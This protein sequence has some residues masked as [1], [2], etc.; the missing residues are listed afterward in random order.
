MTV[1]R[2]KIIDAARKRSRGELVASQL[3]ILGDGLDAAATDAEIPD[4]R[5]ALMFACAHPAI[6]TGIR[7]PLILQ[8]V[9]GLDAETIASAF[10]TS[11]AAMAKRLVRAKDK[12]RQAGIAF[13]IPEREAL[14]RRLDAVLDAIYAAFAEG[15]T[16]PWG[17][18]AARRDLTEEALFLARLVGRAAAGRAGGARPAGAD[19]ARRGAASGPPHAATATTCRLPNRTRRC[20]IGRRS[21]RPRRCCGAPAAHGVIGRYQLEAALQSA[22][23]YRCRTGHANWAEIVQLYDALMAHCPLARRRHQSR[24]RARRSGRRQCRA[25]SPAGGRGRCQARRIPTLLGGARRAAGENAAPKAKR[26]APTTWQSASSATRPFAV[27]A[28]AAGG[29]GGLIACADRV[30]WLNT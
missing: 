16:D 28:A 7:A 12:I 13:A 3:Q 4:R 1:A 21:P 25:G 22:H 24:A 6:E 23:V 17:T 15:W 9:L 29:A 10:L 19:A 27:S 26:A 20:G 18:D 14:P 2:R 30:G 8:V 5:L 11:P